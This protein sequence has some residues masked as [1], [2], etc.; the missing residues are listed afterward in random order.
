MAR[1]QFCDRISIRSELLF[2]IIEATI[3]LQPQQ[4][5]SSIGF[6]P[7]DNCVN[8]YKKNLEKESNLLEKVHSLCSIGGTMAEQHGSFGKSTL[9]PIQSSTINV[10]VSL[11]KC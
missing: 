5:N 2:C 10:I 1:K 7:R 8:I 9:R 4:K 11:S 6:L 3:I